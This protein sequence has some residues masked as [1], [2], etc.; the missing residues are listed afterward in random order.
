[1]MPSDFYSIRACTKDSLPANDQSPRTDAEHMTVA[2]LSEQ[3]KSLGEPSNISR[4]WHRLAGTNDY[5]SHSGLRSVTFPL[6]H[7]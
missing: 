7:L 2:M 3:L 5:D 4:R 6:S 1:M